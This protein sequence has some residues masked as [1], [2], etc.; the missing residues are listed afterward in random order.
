VLQQGVVNFGFL[1]CRGSSDH[2]DLPGGEASVDA[3]RD[4]IA[5]TLAALSNDDLTRLRT[6]V[7]HRRSNTGA[8][9]WA[10][11]NS[12]PQKLGNDE[13]GLKWPMLGW[14]LRGRRAVV[15]NETRR[16]PSS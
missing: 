1:A 3:M 15:L 2:S 6:A 14:A 7:P 9:A 10:S 13:R 11:R 5:A 8:A 4:A 16:G 12:R